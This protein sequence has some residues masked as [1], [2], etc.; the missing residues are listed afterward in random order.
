MKTDWNNWSSVDL[1][2]EYTNLKDTTDNDILS[3][4]NNNLDESDSSEYETD[5]SDEEEKNDNSTSESEV[6]V[7]M[8]EK[9]IEELANELMETI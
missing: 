6:P 7:V 9:Q 2:D 3:L 5:E 4:M 8:D 1:E